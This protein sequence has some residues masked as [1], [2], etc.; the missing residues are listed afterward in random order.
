LLDSENIHLKHKG[1]WHDTQLKSL[2]GAEKQLSKLL[3]D[4][5]NPSHIY[6]PSAYTSSINT[7]LGKYLNLHMVF[8]HP[9]CL[10]LPAP[11]LEAFIQTH[12]PQCLIAFNI[13]AITLNSNAVGA[14]PIDSEELR[15]S[16]RKHFPNLELLDT[17]EAC[18]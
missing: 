10:K 7:R 14:S 18:T 13:K 8:R 9:E 1:I 11:E 2:I 6:I 12:N 17:M 4:T 3:Y 15:Q 16:L 5:G